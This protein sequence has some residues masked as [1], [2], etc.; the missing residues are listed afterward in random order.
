MEYDSCSLTVDGSFFSGNQAVTGS[1]IGSYL[2]YDR[3]ISITNSSFIDNGGLYL[4]GAISAGN[5]VRLDIANSTFSNN[6][7]SSQASV[8]SVQDRAKVTLTH[9]T[10]VDNRASSSGATVLRRPGNRGWFRLRNSII[11]GD[12][13]GRHC[14]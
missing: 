8:L 2:A 1:A 10:I 9:L 11:A 7:S 14:D 4:G 12:E 13:S 6:L 5:V 3:A